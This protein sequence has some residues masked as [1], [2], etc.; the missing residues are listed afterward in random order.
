[1]SRVLFSMPLAEAS[2]R[3]RRSRRASPEDELSGTSAGGLPRFSRMWRSAAAKSA[4][5]QSRRAEPAHFRGAY[6][7]Q[8]HLHQDESLYEKTLLANGCRIIP[9]PQI[10]DIVLYRQVQKRPPPVRQRGFLFRGLGDISSSG[11]TGIS[12]N[13]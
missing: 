7:P 13:R 11:L 8:W 6:G 5:W 3:G 9:A 10:A 2:R 1:L 12:S 4:E